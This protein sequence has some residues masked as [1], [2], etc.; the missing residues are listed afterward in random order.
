VSEFSQFKPNSAG[1][2]RSLKLSLKLDAFSSKNPCIYREFSWRR[3]SESNPNRSI[4]ESILPVFIGWST[5][6]P[7]LFLTIFSLHLLAILLA[8]FGV[9]AGRLGLRVGATSSQPL[10]RQLRQNRI[11]AATLSANT[12]RPSLVRFLA[13][14]VSDARIIRRAL[15][16]QLTNNRPVKMKSPLTFRHTKLHESALPS[17]R[18]RILS[19]E[20]F[21]S[22]KRRS[23]SPRVRPRS[24][25][26]KKRTEA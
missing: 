19:P 13:V 24:C 26:L 7:P 15:L 8:M 23:R 4:S 2:V 18:V 17:T 3:G 14:A 6:I 22:W 16:L 9:Q 5:T 10:C 20:R 12:R 11:A 21:R 1:V 25:G